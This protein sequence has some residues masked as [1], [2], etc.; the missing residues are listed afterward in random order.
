MRA[1]VFLPDAIQRA[2]GL[3]AYRSR[4]PDARKAAGPS[5]RWRRLGDQRGRV[6]DGPLDPDVVFFEVECRAE[7]P[8]AARDIGQR[9]LGYVAPLLTHTLARYDSEDDRSKQLSR[10]FAH[11]LV[12]GL[13]AT[14]ED[15]PSG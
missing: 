5:I 10:T 13:P 7:G 4:F 1:E 3:Q 14:I 12:I 11:V 9:F 2:T 6:I 15:P 8:S